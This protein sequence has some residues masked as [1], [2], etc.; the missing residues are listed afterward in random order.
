MEQPLT[1][2]EKKRRGRML[3]D[4]SSSFHEILQG[5]MLMTAPMKGNKMLEALVIGQTQTH[6]IIFYADSLEPRKMAKLLMVNCVYL[7]SYGCPLKLEGLR[8]F[9]YEHTDKSDMQARE[10]IAFRRRVEIM[11]FEARVINALSDY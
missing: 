5:D 7:G 1:E 4:L 6:V 9:V 8:K 10:K 11:T 3:S 2:A